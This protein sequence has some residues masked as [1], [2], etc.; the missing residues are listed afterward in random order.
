MPQNNKE[1]AALPEN[2]QKIGQPKPEQK[3]IPKETVVTLQQPASTPKI[4]E[5]VAQGMSQL[6]M[7]KTENTFSKELEIIKNRPKQKVTCQIAKK[8]LV[9]LFLRLIIV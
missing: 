5:A 3:T 2:K 4:G 9:R 6:S 1:A 8:H 7:H